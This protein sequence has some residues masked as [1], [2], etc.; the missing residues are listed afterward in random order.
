MTVSVPVSVIKESIKEV[1]NETFDS[2]VGMFLDKGD[3]LWETLENVTAE[4]ASVPI[5]S[6]GNSIAGQINH[7]TYYLEIL[8]VYMHNETP[9]KPDWGEAWKTIEVDENQWQ[10]L[11]QALKERQR[12]IFSLIDDAP[13]ETFADPD[14]L[15]GTYSIVAHTAFHLGQIRHALAVQGR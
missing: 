9:E 11:K 14:I 1:L 12:E 4:Q 2:V 8:S 5:A 10:D 15:G 6:G 7:I 13:D 3:S